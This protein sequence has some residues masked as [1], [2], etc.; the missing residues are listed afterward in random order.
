[1]YRLV[2]RHGTIATSHSMVL[3]MKMKNTHWNLTRKKNTKKCVLAF[4]GLV[5]A[6]PS[7]LNDFTFFSAN[8]IDDHFHLLFIT[9]YGFCWLFFPICTDSASVDLSTTSVPTQHLTKPNEKKNCALVS[10]ALL[11]AV[12][13]VIELQ[14]VMCV[15]EII[16]TFSLTHGTCH[17]IVIATLKGKCR[18]TE[19][20][21]RKYK[22]KNEFT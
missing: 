16:Y 2:S 9:A 19:N 10:I 8:I 14:N 5:H 15:T 11:A 20:K 4:I 22:E 3:N 18:S 13:Y 1:M 17:F 6:A 7:H 12:I 21:K